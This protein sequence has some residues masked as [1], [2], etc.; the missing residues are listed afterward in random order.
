MDIVNTLKKNLDSD[1]VTILC[2]KQASGQ[3]GKTTFATPESLYAAIVVKAP[4]ALPDILKLANEI[5]FHLVPL[6]S[7]NN[8]GYGSIP[9]QKLTKPL[10]ILDLG[11][12][13]K[14]TP[15]SKELGLITLQP[16]VTQQELYDYLKQNNWDYMVPVTGAGPSCSILSNALERGYGI[17]PR[18]DH[19]MAVNA[20]KAYLP[21]PELCHTQYNS[22]VSELDQSKDDFIDKTYKWGLGPYLDGLFTQSNLAVV[23]EVT[24]R[25]APK[26]VYFSSFYLQIFNNDNF[27]DSVLLIREFL[28]DFETITGS[29]NL[30]DRNRLISMTAQNPNGTD[31]H[32]NMTQEQVIQL[33]NNKR[34]PE[35]MIVGSLYGTKTIVNSAKKEFKKRAK[36]I[37][38]VY[39]SD[40]L[41]LKLATTLAK[42]PLPSLSAIDNIKSQLLSLQQGQ[43]IMLG[44]PNQVAL[45][46]AYWRNPRVE[47]NKNNALSPAQDECGL[48]WYAPLIPMLPEK[49]AEFVK[50]VKLTTPKYGIE[51]L[52]TFTNLKHDCID[53]TVPIVF[54]LHNSEAK[55]SAHNC[56]DELISEGKKRG[57]VPYRMDVVQQQ[58]LDPNQLFWKTV[59]LLKETIDPNNVISPGRY[60][61]SAND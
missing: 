52:I 60:A 26:P 51:P 27:Q 19:F 47:P 38:K 2:E 57:F 4:N 36:K 43:E 22:A 3:Y 39:F 8:W 23:T 10:I 25:L 12:L 29:I 15:T 35:W 21:H 61:P 30:M 5:G 44:K 50:F 31:K 53:S 20:L 16:G 7:G 49:L 56:L 11:Q 14:I 42:V 55:K 6:S 24:I 17:T 9:K 32:T 41:L 28:K 40:S 18:T 48:L 45:P 1:L 54:D 59:N 58:K 37:G 13:K 33:A 34:L 46:L